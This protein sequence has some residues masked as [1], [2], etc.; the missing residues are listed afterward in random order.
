MSAVYN[1][2]ELTVENILPSHMDMDIAKFGLCSGLVHSTGSLGSFQL[3]IHER[4]NNASS[5]GAGFCMLLLDSWT[6]HGLST[7]CLK[8]KTDQKKKKVS[9]RENGKVLG[10]TTSAIQSTRPV[11][12]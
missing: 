6:A 9:L 2:V 1:C 10:K 11:L 12:I 7:T 8:V 5:W 4:G 3:V